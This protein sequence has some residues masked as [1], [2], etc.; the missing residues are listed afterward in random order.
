MWLWR[1]VM[2]RKAITAFALL[3]ALQAIAAPGLCAIH[4]R[5]STYT[6]TSSR[7]SAYGTKQVDEA[8]VSPRLDAQGASQPQHEDSELDRC[9]APALLPADTLAP[10]AGHFAIVLDMAPAW[11]QAAL[12]PPSLGIAV[13]RA[14]ARAQSSPLDI[15][16]RLRN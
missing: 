10:A 16:P 2:A 1:R 13:R 11:H 5:I 7:V 3:F 8:E 6:E 12:Q 4:D 9:D 15:A 14:P